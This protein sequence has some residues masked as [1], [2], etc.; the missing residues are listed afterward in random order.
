MWLDTRECIP[1]ADGE[2]VVQTV[3]GSVQAL[4]YTHKA[5][6]NTYYDCKGVLQDDKPIEFDYIARWYKVEEP[7]EVPQKWKDDYLNRKEQ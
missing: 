7:P 5:G 1:L 4:Q 2:Y 6:W 3:F